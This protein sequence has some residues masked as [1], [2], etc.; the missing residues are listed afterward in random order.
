V[1]K[2]RHLKTVKC[3]CGSEFLILPDIDKM[4]E[5]VE[6]HA[7]VHK[8]TEQDS[9]KAKR[10]YEEIRDYLIEEIFKELR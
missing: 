2:K 8:E 7:Q 3:K 4:S 10:L 1:R 5:I 9:I 6:K